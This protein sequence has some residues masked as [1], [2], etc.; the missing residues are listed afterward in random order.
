MMEVKKKWSD[1]KWEVNK[2]TG[3]QKE[4]M[5][6]TGGQLAAPAL[7]TASI[8]GYTACHGAVDGHKRGTDER[9]MLAILLNRLQ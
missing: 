8:L 1:N 6:D 4:S 2:R 7:S 3:A 5:R 9:G